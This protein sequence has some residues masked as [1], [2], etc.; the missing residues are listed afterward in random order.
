MSEATHTGAGGSGAQGR[1]SSRISARAIRILGAVLAVVLLAA[2]GAAVWLGLQTRAEQKRERERAAAVNVATQF[3]LRMD[4]VDGAAYDNYVKG[5]SELLTTKAK[6]KNA[7][8]FKAVKQ[9]Y[10]AAKVKGSGKVLVAGVGAADEDSATVL[11][12]HDAE[13]TST[14]GSVQRYYRWSVSTVKVDGSWLV[15]DFTPVN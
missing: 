7:E 14:Q 4:Q 3:A 10:E 13:V 9:S 1:R 11:V 5:V 12:V 2:A 6:S 15:D 8:V